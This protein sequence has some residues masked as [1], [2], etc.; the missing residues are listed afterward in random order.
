MSAPTARLR[1]KAA[2]LHLVFIVHE[3]SEWDVVCTATDTA[4]SASA[5]DAT[6]EVIFIQQSASADG[7]T[8]RLFCKQIAIGIVVTGQTGVGVGISISL[9]G[10]ISVDIGVGI[11]RRCLRVHQPASPSPVCQCMWKQSLQL[12]FGLNGF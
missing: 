7:A 3:L 1:G 4:E 11:G 9:R 5:H 12:P 8:H 2:F 6:R 10:H